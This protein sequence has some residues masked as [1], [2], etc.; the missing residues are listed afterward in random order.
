MKSRLLSQEFCVFR[1]GPAVV[2]S[3]GVAVCIVKSLVMHPADRTG[4]L[5]AW[6][7]CF[8]RCSVSMA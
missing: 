5:L 4:N 7:L 2:L 3:K 1:A 6:R 8:K